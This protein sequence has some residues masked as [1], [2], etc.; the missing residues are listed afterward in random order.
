MLKPL[1]FKN[2]PNTV[3]LNLIIL[4]LIISILVFTGTL[5]FPK[6]Y[7]AYNTYFIDAQ[8]MNTTESIIDFSPQQLAEKTTDNVKGII[9]SRN[10][11]GSVLENAGSESNSKTREKLG[12]KLLVKKVGPQVLF[13]QIRGYS[14]SDSLERT[15][16]SLTQV[17]QTEIS[18]INSNGNILIS[19]NEVN[20]DP[21][22]EEVILYPYLN[23]A[24]AFLITV[25]LGV[26]I[27]EFKKYIE[28]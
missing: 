6:Q 18:S 23:A 15:I 3:F 1:F 7:R 24:L 11:L 2:K 9:E 28:K 13:V 12:K 21:N 26:S 4:G 17:L 10:F 14:D 16:T 19:L 25:I 22:V 27:Y 20:E 8:Y 5:L